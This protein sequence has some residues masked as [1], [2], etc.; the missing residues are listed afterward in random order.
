MKYR[1]KA[2]I[3]GNVVEVYHYEHRIST[4]KDGKKSKGGSKALN[5]ECEEGERELRDAK[6]LNDSLRRTKQNLRRTINSNIGKWGEK[7]KFLTLTFAENM[8]DQAVTNELFSDFMKRL[9][10]RVFKSKKAQLKYV[11]VVE[12]QER[13]AI[14]YHVVF[15]NLPFIEAN[16]IASVWG[17]GF[18]KV[19]AIDDVDNMGAYVVKYM[20]KTAVQDSEKSA[21]EKNKKLYFVARGLHKPV[22]YCDSTE[23][24]QINIATIRFEFA[25]QKV[26]QNSF[27]N[28]HTGLVEYEQYNLGRK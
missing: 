11:C 19:N 15:F 22:E 7:D 26:Y 14:H 24:G 21:K 17:H 27:S 25:D 3:S 4:G 23:E 2:I 18:I 5:T 12:R 16:E 6:N 13:G 1:I 20:S 9:N 8:T 10:Y 28:E